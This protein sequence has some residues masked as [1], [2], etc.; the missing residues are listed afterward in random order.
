MNPK[1]K[2]LPIEKVKQNEQ[3]PRVIRDLKFQKLV[4]S[5]KDFP[6]MASV[7]PLIL[8]KE[9]IVLGGNQCLKAMQEAGWK[10]VPCIIVDWTEDKQ[11]EFVIKDNAN[12]GEWDWQELLNFSEVDLLKDWG[13]DL[14]ST[15]FEPNLEPDFNHKS[16]T[17]DDINKTSENMG[18]NEGIA[19][20]IEVICP[21]CGHEFHIKNIH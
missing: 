16:V 21:D 4:Q 11:R 17:E 8:N 20:T 7:R 6:E 18:I 1:T 3:N 13:V 14:P 12:F 10:E 9:N 2:F 15:S 19:K 5:L